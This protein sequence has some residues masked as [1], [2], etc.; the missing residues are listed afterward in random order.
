MIQDFERFQNEL[1]AL[2][3]LFGPSKR[4]DVVLPRLREI[5]EYTERKWCAYAGQIPQGIV[6]YVLIAEAP[7]WSPEGRPQFWLDPESGVQLN[8]LRHLFCRTRLDP[9]ANVLEVAA[10]HGFLIL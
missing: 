10:K 4:L 2:R 5:Y 3:K 6:Q 9:Y 1:D 8:A 7:P